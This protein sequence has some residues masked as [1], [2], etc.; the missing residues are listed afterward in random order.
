[1]LSE[2]N[3]VVR[4]N[5]RTYAHARTCRVRVRVVFNELPYAI[6]KCITITKSSGAETRVY[7]L[8][9]YIVHKI[10]KYTAG[11]PPCE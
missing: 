8:H 9:V 1:M 2:Q 3:V 10:Y 5:T 7:V 4:S 11:N 6:Y